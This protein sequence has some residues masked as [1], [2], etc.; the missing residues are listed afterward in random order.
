MLTDAHLHLQDTLF[1]ENI[2][3]VIAR[4]NAAGVF[5]FLCA[6][7]TLEDSET[8]LA[9]CSHFKQIT[10]FIGTHP[11][12]AQK[13]NK[14][15]LKKL[16]EKNP[17]ANIGETGLDALKPNPFQEESFLD[18][19]SLS[20][21]FDR[22]F[23]VHCVKAAQDVIRCLKRFKNLPPFLCHA[24]YGGKNEI[25]FLADKGAYFSL[26][27]RFF[28]RPDFEKKLS[29]YPMNRILIE[30]DSPFMRPADDFCIDKTQKHNLPE[31]LSL[32][33]KH[34]S[35][36]YHLSEPDFGMILKTNLAAFLKETP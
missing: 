18:H 36:L 19:I 33:F 32:T 11:W 20:V 22:P 12:F 8:L 3:S 17:N 1:S 24:L 6:S 27:A 31:N 5:R 30:T 2:A 13:H 23:I 4:A 26:N 9:L 16:L 34:L 21:A 35:Q 14:K 28:T 15:R 29:F 10:P 25:D 7:A